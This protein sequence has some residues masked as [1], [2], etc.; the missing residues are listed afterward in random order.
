MYALFSAAMVER[1]DIRL[2]ACVAASG[3]SD[4]LT[5]KLIKYRW[6]PRQG[7][8][9]AFGGA[10]AAYQKQGLSSVQ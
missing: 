6:S 7:A 8:S 4:V 1:I 2:L 3:A 10:L 5:L 9:S